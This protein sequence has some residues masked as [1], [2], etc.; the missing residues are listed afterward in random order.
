M[1]EVTRLACKVRK[2]FY[3]LIQTLY[4]TLFSSITPLDWR[5]SNWVRRVRSMAAR[6]IN[7]GQSWSI[8][9][10]LFHHTYV[11][12]SH[13]PCDIHVA[14][15]PRP[16]PLLPSHRQHRPLPCRL[17]IRLHRS[18]LSRARY[19]GNSNL[20]RH[21]H[22]LISGIFFFSSNAGLDCFFHW[23]SRIFDFFQTR[24]NNTVTSKLDRLEF[25]LDDKVRNVTA[26]FSVSAL[27]RNETL[28]T[29]LILL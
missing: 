18:D 3:F 7:D 9:T 25:R 2:K 4:Y 11:Y 29:F 24:G 23:K 12:I 13:M 1:N 14:G 5:Y 16:R 22:L 15:C 27:I 20:K 6:L 17:A 21:T 8:C 26:D 28:I 19:I 10:M